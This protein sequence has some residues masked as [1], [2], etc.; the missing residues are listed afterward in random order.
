MQIDLSPISFRP[1]TQRSAVCKHWQVR[2]TVKSTEEKIKVFMNRHGTY[3]L[4]PGL[5]PEPKQIGKNYNNLTTLRPKA[6]RASQSPRRAGE[7]GEGT[8]AEGPAER[9]RHPATAA[10]ARTHRTGRGEI[11]NANTVI[12]LGSKIALP[13]ALPAEHRQK[14]LQIL[15]QACAGVIS[16]L[17][18]QPKNAAKKNPTQPNQPKRESSSGCC[19]DTI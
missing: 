17:V 4:L 2:S 7:G 11:A 10:P 1:Q 12:A 5:R 18:A 9:H 3:K 19:K 13:T 8:R 6:Q 15:P 16:F 14:K